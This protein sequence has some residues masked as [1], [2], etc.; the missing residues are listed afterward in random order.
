MFVERIAQA[1]VDGHDV[2]NLK[3]CSI[4]SPGWCSGVILTT[5]EGI[6]KEG[7]GT[8]GEDTGTGKVVTHV[9]DVRDEQVK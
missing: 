5:W 1:R 7:R 6:C 2:V 4:M 9:K 8:L 3:T